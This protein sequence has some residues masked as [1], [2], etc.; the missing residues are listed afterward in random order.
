MASAPYFEAPGAGVGPLLVQSFDSA[1]ISKL[2]A[3][4]NVINMFD[5][6]G[7]PLN[8]VSEVHKDFNEVF[9]ELNLKYN[10]RLQVQDTLERMNRGMKLLSAKEQDAVNKLVSE[11]TEKD[12]VASPLLHI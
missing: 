5:A 6:A 7:I 8:K 2:L 11:S 10:M 9:K 3:K 1:V 12:A 4:H